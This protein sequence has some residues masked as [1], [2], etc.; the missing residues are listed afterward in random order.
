MNNVL[1]LILLYAAVIFLVLGGIGLVYS[2]LW[3]IIDDFEDDDD[4]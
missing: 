4:V 3:D 2:I 1:A